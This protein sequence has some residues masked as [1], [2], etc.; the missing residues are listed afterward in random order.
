MTCAIE[1]T[2][3]AYQS[4]FIGSETLGDIFGVFRNLATD[5]I[6]TN[7]II[8]YNMQNYAAGNLTHPATYEWQLR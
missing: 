3:N 1:F 2:R 6:D 8:K 7:E 5:V 4:R